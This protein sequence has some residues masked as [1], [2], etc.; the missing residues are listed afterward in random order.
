MGLKSLRACIG[1]ACKSLS[2]HANVM[3]LVPM[4]LLPGCIVRSVD[5]RQVV[6]VSA[7]LL[8]P[9]VAYLR[10]SVLLILL[11]SDCGSSLVMFLGSSFGV[12]RFPV[13]LLPLS[14]ATLFCPLVD[15]LGQNSK[16]LSEF[17]IS[18]GFFYL[19][20]HHV[21]DTFHIYRMP[22]HPAGG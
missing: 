18:H 7:V 2:L 3:V 14:F 6:S 12:Y 5:R 8:G 4:P 17:G 21:G 16:V 13:I 11:P 19:F 22:V 20:L 15:L 10:I 9:S 1:P